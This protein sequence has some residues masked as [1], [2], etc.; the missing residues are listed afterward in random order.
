MALKIRVIT[1][2]ERGVE[3]GGTLNIEKITWIGR[4]IKKNK[5]V[6]DGATFA[7]NNLK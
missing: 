6:R 4:H 2:A 5:F 3:P 7:M 1:Y